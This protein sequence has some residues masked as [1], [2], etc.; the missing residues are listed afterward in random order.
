[1]EFLKN[2]D[3]RSGV[4][5]TI[6]FHLLLLL[7]F[8]FYG[9][10]E[11]HPPIEEIGMPLRIKLGMISEGT[12]NVKAEN[13]GEPQQSEQIENEISES[14]N[15]SSSDVSEKT[16]TQNV[17]ETVTID[18]SEEKQEKKE[19]PVKE[20]E[21]SEHLR[22]M[23]NIFKDKVKQEGGSEGT[24]NKTGQQGNPDGAIEGDVEGGPIPGG[25]T[26][27]LKGRN[28]LSISKPTDTSQEEGAVVVDIVVDR[29]GNVISAK[30][31]GAGSTTNS[32][33]LFKKAKESS[34]KTKFS[35]NSN[36]PFEQHGQITYIFVLK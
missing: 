5:G 10:K 33:I 7:V 1:M 28:L 22:H 29:K 25:G 15:E 35:P 21:P 2:K 18:K 12:G 8:M 4:I 20:P 11:P 26:W 31:G 13:T 27:K 3:R 36:A 19:E 34:L 24:T 32:H 23:L 14:M 9:L 6:L 30:P 17:T 16:V